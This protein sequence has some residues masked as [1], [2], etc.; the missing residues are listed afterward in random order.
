M[1]DPTA[2]ELR[3]VAGRINWVLGDSFIS[4]AEDLFL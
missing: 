1:Y 2:P 3:L 4:A